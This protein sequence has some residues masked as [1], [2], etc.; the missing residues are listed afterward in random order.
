MPRT[1]KRAGA[2]QNT[3]DM[4]ISEK[5][6]PDITKRRRKKVITGRSINTSKNNGA[7]VKLKISRTNSL[8]RTQVE[9]I[10]E[11]KI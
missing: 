1:P 4:K 9:N 11:S 2:T 6:K 7:N 5:L 3:L 8:E 10:S